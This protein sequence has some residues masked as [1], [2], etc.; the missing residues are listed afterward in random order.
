[1]KRRELFR[2]L[3]TSP[4]AALPLVPKPL[5]SGLVFVGG[6]TG[7]LLPPREPRMGV[8]FGACGMPAPMDPRDLAALLA[9]F[10]QCGHGPAYHSHDGSGR[11]TYGDR[12]PKPPAHPS[13]DCDCS[14][15]R[16]KP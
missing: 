6:A 12:L 16:K 3:G 5:T 10:C 11:C 1:M 4:I 7:A 13:W 2:L 9:T 14:M 15:F 8:T